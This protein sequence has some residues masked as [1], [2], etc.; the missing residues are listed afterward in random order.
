MYLI[1]CATTINYVYVH[2]VHTYYMHTFLC[3]VMLRVIVIILHDISSLDEV[4]KKNI[5]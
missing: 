3:H 5:F 4:L 2:T 1:Y